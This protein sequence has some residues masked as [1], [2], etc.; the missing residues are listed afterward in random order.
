MGRT[1]VIGAEQP[2][3][4]EGQGV[5]R[6]RQGSRQP[7]EAQVADEHLGL[8]LREALEEH[9]RAEAVQ[10]VAPQRQSQGG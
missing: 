1:G 2:E 7:V 5:R 3:R 8:F 10:L 6:V 9:G 4:D